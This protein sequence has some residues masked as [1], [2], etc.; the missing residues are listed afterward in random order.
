VIGV[1]VV[2]TSAI[3][4]AE[5][6]LPEPDLALMLRTSGVDP[7]SLDSVL[8]A[9]RDS[10]SPADRM[11][12]CEFLSYR[13][14]QASIEVLKSALH[15]S[16]PH[17]RIGAARSLLNLGDRSGLEQMRK[18]WESLVPEEVRRD[19]TRM[20]DV[21][22]Y[23]LRLALRVGVVLTDF[24]DTR[25]LA[26][27]AHAAS[28]HSVAVIRVD[29][30][31]VLARGA[32]LDKEQVRDSGVD[33]SA[34]LLRLAASEKDELVQGVIRSRSSKLSAD[35]ALPI[36]E[37]LAQSS[38]LS[39]QSRRGVRRT[40]EAKK[41]EAETEAKGNVSTTQPT[42]HPATATAPKE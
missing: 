3:A 32:K 16:E 20:T 9:A 40:I 15:D 29:A 27:A 8:A 12:A 21:N 31:N 1:A 38:H 35:V 7:D 37:T 19:P 25:A 28:A 11:V 34:V 36:L 6:W 42:T 39:D 10:K 18:D 33:P 14:G 5:A 13:P 4:R 26:L 41:A 2:A 17:V 22:R 24:G 23:N 30:L